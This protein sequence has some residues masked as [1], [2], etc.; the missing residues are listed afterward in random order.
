M[1]RG[2]LARLPGAM[3]AGRPRS[4]KVKPK[5]TKFIPVRSTQWNFVFLGFTLIPENAVASAKGQ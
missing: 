2:R 3:R 5:S 1:E 4:I